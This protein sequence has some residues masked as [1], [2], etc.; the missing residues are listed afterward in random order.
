LTALLGGLL[1]PSLKGR[2]DRRGERFRSSVALIDELADGLWA[3]WKLALRVSYYGRQGERAS[4]EFD[5]ALRRWDDDES[6][7][8]GCAIQ[9]NVSRSKR[10]LP[11]PAHEKLDRGQRYVVDYLDSEI[12]RLRQ[13]S[14]AAEWGEFYGSLMTEKRAEIDSILTSATEVLRL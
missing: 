5:V 12:D 4:E 2:L 7:D 13:S 1:A 3:Y 11:L 10:L 6:W 14:S 8:I 9:I